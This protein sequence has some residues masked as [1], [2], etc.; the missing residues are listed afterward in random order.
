MTNTT[1]QPL[2]R[3][4]KVQL[5]GEGNSIQRTYGLNGL[6]D[7]ILSMGVHEGLTPQMDATHF[8]LNP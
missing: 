7:E 8:E 4:Y 1:Q 3:K 2:K 6:R 5:I